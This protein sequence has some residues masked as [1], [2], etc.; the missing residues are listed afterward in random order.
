ME[1]L[2]AVDA[3]VRALDTV[4]FRPCADGTLEPGVEKVALFGTIGIFG[5]VTPSRAARQLA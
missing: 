2:Y 4:G 3:Y 5:R 1:R